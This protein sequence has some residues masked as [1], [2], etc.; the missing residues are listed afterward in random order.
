MVI[1]G[2]IYKKILGF[3]LLLP[4]IRFAFFSNTDV[5]EMKKPSVVLSVVIGGCMDCFQ[6]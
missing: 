5:T 2:D 3:L 4:V 1:N 6:V